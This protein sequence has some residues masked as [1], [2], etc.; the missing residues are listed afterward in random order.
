M[1]SKVL[2]CALSL[3]V[4]RLTTFPPHD[5]TTLHQMGL[6]LPMLLSEA[7]LIDSLLITAQSTDKARFVEHSAYFSECSHCEHIPRVG[8]GFRRANE[9]DLTLFLNEKILG[10]RYWECS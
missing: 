10:C 3:L 5:L 9:N 1:S 6:N 2:E 8:K 4:A 7:F